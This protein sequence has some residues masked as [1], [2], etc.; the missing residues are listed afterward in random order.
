MYQI[1]KHVKWRTSWH[2][3]QGLEYRVNCDIET[4]YVG[5]AGML[6]HIHGKFTMGEFYECLG[7]YGNISSS[8]LR[9]QRGHTFFKHENYLLCIDAT[10]P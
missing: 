10:V 3:P 6:L 4:L 5:A 1:G 8:V 9:K 7:I 2:K